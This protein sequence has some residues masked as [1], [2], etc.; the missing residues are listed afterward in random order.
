VPEQSALAATAS[1]H[2]HERIATMYVEGNIVEHGTV[3]EFPDEMIYLDDG[4]RVSGH[5]QN[6]EIRMTKLE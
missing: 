1:A 2:D 4:G 6:D 3:S 5:E